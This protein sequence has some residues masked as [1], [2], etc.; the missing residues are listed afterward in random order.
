MV[1]VFVFGETSGFQF[2]R[3]T[4]LALV[5]KKKRNRLRW[6]SELIDGRTNTWNTNLVRQIMAG[7]DVEEI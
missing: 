6:V 1:K 5:T 3:E 2:P 4:S 7:P